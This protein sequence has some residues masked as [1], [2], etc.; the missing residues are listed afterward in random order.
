[1]GKESGVCLVEGGEGTGPNRPTDGDNRWKVMGEVGH[2]GHREIRQGDGE[3]L[4]RLSEL[5]YTG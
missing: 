3:A 2:A 4:N 5:G 1:M